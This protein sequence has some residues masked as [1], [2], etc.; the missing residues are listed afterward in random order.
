M[1][2][3]I[4]N[5]LT[6]VSKQ[7]MIE[8]M[9][10]G[11]M[12]F[13]NSIPPKRECVWVLIAQWGLETGFGQFCH[14]YN[15]GNVK[16]SDGDGYDY[17]FFG[18]GEEITLAQ[19]NQWIAK[20]PGLVKI[21]RTYTSDKGIQMASV[22]VEPKHWASRFRAFNTLLEG[23][24]DY[25][26]ILARRFSKAWPSVLA[27]DP[28]A[29]SHAIKMQGYYTD[30]EAHYTKTLMATFKDASKVPFDYDSLPVLT[31]TEKERISN[32]VSL[33]VWDS[34]GEILSAEDKEPDEP[35][36]A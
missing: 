33:T 35:G 36:N 3:E 20:D 28:A 11:W 26:A 22:W 2:V 12:A 8:A 1:P 27:G 17:Q 7:D 6:P 24:V 34:V 15:L 9:W 5:K 32:L 13:F 4:P 30:N 25:I 23:T 21:Q 19:A 10:R 29:F 31:D 14:N 18:C 16:S